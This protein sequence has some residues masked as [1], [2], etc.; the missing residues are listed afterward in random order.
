MPLPFNAARCCRVT[1]SRWNRILIAGFVVLSALDLL[2]TWRLVEGT[3]GLVY[4]ANP[5]ASNILGEH[6][7]SGLSVFKLICVGI[8]IT[9]GLIVLRARPRTGKLLFGGASCGMLGV[10]GYSLLLMI[11]QPWRDGMSEHLIATERLRGD[12]LRQEL[13]ESKS[14]AAKLDALVEDLVARQQTLPEAT[15]EL[16]HFVAE[17]R[18]FNPLSQ[19]RHTYPD[20]SDDAR[21]S[22]VLLRHVAATLQERPAADRQSLDTLQAQFEACYA[23]PPP[24]FLGRVNRG[25]ETS[26]GR[27]LRSLRKPRHE[28]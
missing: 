25:Q 15:E 14:Y 18:S 1:G 5:L 22:V 4:E 26:H 21:L 2:L 7:W 19:L 8:F 24:D 10:V 12:S 16:Y 23:Q 11:A 17:P 28:M 3:G 13:H 27:H 20:L 6:G 9:A